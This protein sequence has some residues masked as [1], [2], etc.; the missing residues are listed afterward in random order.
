MASEFAT[1]S[2]G[3]LPTSLG[4]ARACKAL[5]PIALTNIDDKVERERAEKKVADHAREVLSR[6][7]RFIAFCKTRQDALP[8]T[9]RGD[10]GAQYVLDSIHAHAFRITE[11]TKTPTVYRIDFVCP[12]A[13]N[14]EWD[15]LHRGVRG[16]VWEGTHGHA[17]PMKQDIHCGYWKGLDHPTV[18]CP[19]KKEGGYENTITTATPITPE[20]PTELPPNPFDEILQ[21]ED[22]RARASPRPEKAPQRGAPNQQRQRAQPPPPQ[23]RPPP[24]YQPHFT[25]PQYAIQG[26]GPPYQARGTAP[27]GRGR[28]ASRPRPPY[29]CREAR[30]TGTATAPTQATPPPTRTTSRPSTT[31]STARRPDTVTKGRDTEPPRTPSVPDHAVAAY[32][33][34]TPPTL[35]SPLP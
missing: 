14:T 8:P 30:R 2:D 23:H 17:Q 13:N 25:H 16:I 33:L 27:R 28:G 1:R 9:V 11:G 6:E 32:P 31:T 22:D 20:E 12:T 18:D 5:V 15:K 24:Q 21:A 26:Y 3:L 7:G 4:R 29:P 10:S 35:P 34:S 19:L